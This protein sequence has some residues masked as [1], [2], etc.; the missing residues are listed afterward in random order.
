MGEHRPLGEARGAPGVLEEGEVL[1]VGDVGLGGGALEEF[2]E[3][4]EAL[5]LGEAQ[6]KAVPLGLQGVEE[7]LGE[8]EEVLDP[9]DHHPLHRDLLFHLQV[10]GEEVVQDHQ[11]LRP[12]IRKLV[13][14]FPGRVEGV[15][16]HPHAPG[17]EGAVEGDD[18]LG[19]VGEHDGH[20][21][22]GPHPQVLK[23]LGEAAGEAP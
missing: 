3:G 22:P 7:V 14:E 23:P 9:R 4:V 6:G 13:A 17:E 18:E 12:R 8:G 10:A 19:R 15:D 21:V 5:P 11:G 16:V 20:P 1:G 2:G